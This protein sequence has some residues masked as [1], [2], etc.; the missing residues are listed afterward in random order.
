MAVMVHWL[1]VAQCIA[2]RTPLQ[3]SGIAGNPRPQLDTCWLGYHQ[4]RLC[5]P[6]PPKKSLSNSHNCS[7]PRSAFREGDTQVFADH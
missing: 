3:Q 6:P 1:K 2:S 4:W 5:P 7:S